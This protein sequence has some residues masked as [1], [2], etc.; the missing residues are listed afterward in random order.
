ML[1]PQLLVG[2][3]V[4]AKRRRPSERAS[5]R[6][7]GKWANKLAQTNELAELTSWLAAG[8]RWSLPRAFKSHWAR[9]QVALESAGHYLLWG[10][11]AR[12][13]P[14]GLGRRRRRLEEQRR[15]CFGRRFKGRNWA[16]FGSGGAQICLPRPCRRPGGLMRLDSFSDL[17]GWL[18]ARSPA[19]LLACWWPAGRPS[20][21][22]ISGPASTSK[23]RRG[24]A[25][26]ARPEAEAEQQRRQ[27][28]KRRS[29]RRRRRQWQQS[30]KQSQGAARSAL[31]D[32][33]S[34]GGG[35]P[36]GLLAAS[37]LPPRAREANQLPLARLQ[38]GPP[39]AGRCHLEAAAALGAHCGA[40]CKI[41]APPLLLRPTCSPPICLAL[42]SSARPIGHRRLY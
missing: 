6:A 14:G 24:G 2:A 5:G 21:Y 28:Q 33:D 15:L 10:R 37:L 40:Q 9:A 32:L 23:R 11:R 16:Q 13:A 39:A 38:R 17:A 7:L 12:V 3:P 26:M 1:L 41:I 18:L 4:F 29:K 36:F 22:L 34:G 30:A 20:T 42:L 35:G 25:R 8:R 27:R 19:C 31:C